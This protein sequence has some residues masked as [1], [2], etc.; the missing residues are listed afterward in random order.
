MDIEKT[1]N[2]DNSADEN[3]IEIIKPE[4]IV[5]IQMSSG[6]YKKIQDVLAT[7]LHGKSGEELSAAHK[8]ISEQNITEA[9]I[10][11]YETLLILAKE[12][13]Y[14]ARKEGF[15]VKVTKEKAAEILQQQLD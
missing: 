13:E 15:V 2:L 11:Q 7:L 12:F 1:P 8:Q 14:Q 5:N 3:L 10:E 6:F 9:W 4:T